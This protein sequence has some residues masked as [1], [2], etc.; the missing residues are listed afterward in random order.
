METIVSIVREESAFRK[1]KP[2]FKTWRRSKR[3][4]KMLIMQR[5]AVSHLEGILRLHVSPLWYTFLL[6]LN[7]SPTPSP[8]VHPILRK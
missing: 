1:L 3:E 7:I 5:S 4:W 6:L 2:G 8:H